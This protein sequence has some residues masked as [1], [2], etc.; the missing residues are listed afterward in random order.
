ATLS[1]DAAKPAFV[2]G[3]SLIV[4]PQPVGR[5]KRLVVRLRKRELTEIGAVGVHPPDVE[6]NA[7]GGVE[8]NKSAVTAYIESALDLAGGGQHPAGCAVGA[9]TCDR[10]APGVGCGED[11]TFV[12]HPS[13][14]P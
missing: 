7:A 13:E 4:D 12:R 11:Q 14:P 5:N 2:P 9:H 1:R 3:E 6:T 8:D 10:H